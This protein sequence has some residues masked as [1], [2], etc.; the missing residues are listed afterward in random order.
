MDHHDSNEIAIVL[1][2][3]HF[4]ASSKFSDVSSYRVDN[5]V[6]KQEQT[7]HLTVNY[8]NRPVQDQTVLR[9]HA[10]Q[11][12]K[13]AGKIENYYLS[14]KG[15][16]IN[17]PKFQPEIQK[18]GI[19]QRINRI[20]KEKPVSQLENDRIRIFEKVRSPE[21]A[22]Q[23]PVVDNA[24]QVGMRGNAVLSPAPRTPISIQVQKFPTQNY[25]NER[26]TK[27]II[28]SGNVIGMRTEPVRYQRL[29]RSPAT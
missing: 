7:Y 26:S 13:A 12:E 4:I 16:A 15:Y 29:E 22:R 2:Q 28:P 20:P 9:K 24:F 11:D 17:I 8:A 19:G 18:E 21:A 27:N 1:P 5:T 10:S 25:P 14:P 23:H 6:N 3:D